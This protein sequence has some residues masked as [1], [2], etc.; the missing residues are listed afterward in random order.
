MTKSKI[1]V[2]IVIEKVEKDLS[3]IS[4][5]RHTPYSAE[6]EAIMANTSKFTERNAWEEVA[7]LETA[8]EE[9]KAFAVA[10]LAKL[11]EKNDKRKNSEAAVAKREADA[12]LRETMLSVMEAG[13]TYT[14]AE[15]GALIGEGTMKASSLALDLTK[16][17]K[18]VQ[19]ETR[20]N[21]RKCKGYTLA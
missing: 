1:Y 13:K 9:L 21:G 20:S 12:A 14:A 6:R 4:K 5:W 17:N 18:V 2:I 16:A 8:S 15:L 19:S 11:D 3:K 7:N 10:R